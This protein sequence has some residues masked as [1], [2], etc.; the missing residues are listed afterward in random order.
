MQRMLSTEKPIKIE[1]NKL[2]V[3]VI[4]LAVLIVVFFL[5]NTLYEGKFLSLSNISILVSHA[6]IPA[7]I[8]WGLCFV[9]ACGY[10]DLSIGAVIVLA[11]NVV[12]TLGNQFGY[13]GVIIGGIITSG[14]LLFLNFNIYVF[15]KIPSWIAGIGMAMLYEAAAVLYSKMRLSRGLTVIELGKEFR[16][17]GQAPYIYIVFIIGFIAAYFLYNRTSL[18]MNI[19]SI[20]SNVEVSRSL[21][22]NVRRTLLMVGVVS[23]IFI[24]IAA[25]LEESYIARMT[26]KT[27]LTSLSLLFQPI[28]AY[29]LA[30]VLQKRIN[31]IVA[32]PICTFVIYTVF[33]MLTIAGI[34]S[35]TWQEAILG[36]IVIVFGMVAQ[37]KA[38]GVIK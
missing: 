11:A 28:A 14:V 31:L 6:I 15:T 29:L 4:L 3:P 27:G 25:I 23:G 19:R 7:F 18:G 30:Q 38:Q 21:G 32:I 36:M 17:L 16:I 35:G 24:G 9:F 20:G 5:F 10:T 22:I 1:R 13:A 12:G 2:Y 8:A 26:A 34:P 37:R 33:N